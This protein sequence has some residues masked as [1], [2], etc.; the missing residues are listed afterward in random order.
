[1]TTEEMSE[2]DDL[3]NYG[4][5]IIA[6]AHGGDWDL[7]SKE[8]Q[9]AATTFHDRYHKLLEVENLGQEVEAPL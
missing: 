4:W 3:L 5:T 8:W 6:N 1:M 9:T 7:A 2:K